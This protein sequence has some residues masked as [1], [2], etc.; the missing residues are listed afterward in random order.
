MLDSRDKTLIYEL[1]WNGRQTYSQLA[2]K[3]KLSKQATRY[4]VEQLEKKRI[5][6]SYHALIDWR[7]LGYDSLRIYIKW[8]NITPEKEQEIYEHIRKSDLFMWSVKFEGEVD[9]AFYVWIKSLVK[10]SKKWFLFLEK[11]GEYILKQEIYE[12]VTMNHYPYKPLSEEYIIDERIIGLTKKEQYDKTDYKILQEVTINA[13][14]PV[15]ELSKKIKL[16]SKATISRLKRLEQKKIIIAYNA[17]IDT[18]KIGYKFYKIDF[19][20]KKYDKITSMEEYAKQH[21]NIVYRMRTIGGPDVEIELMV[22]DVNE[23]RLILDEIRK[24]F[25]ESINHYRLHRFEYTLKQK[26]L[27]GK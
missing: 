4:R 10:F 25:A 5:I 9:I 7:A 2:K 26:Y 3:I 11:Y 17:L 20:L 22:K 6:K 8:Q 18:N 23:M 15:I 1:Q 19:F 12:S 24:L 21:K 27:P 14:I 13:R 16:S